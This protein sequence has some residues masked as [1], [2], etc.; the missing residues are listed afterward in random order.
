VC[1]FVCVCI[2]MYII[3]V[4]VL[5]VESVDLEHLCMEY[6]CLKMSLCFSCVHACVVN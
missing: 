1:V 5:T 6:T 3:Y 2:Q 4:C